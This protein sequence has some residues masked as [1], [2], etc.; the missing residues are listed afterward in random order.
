HLTRADAVKVLDRLA[1]AGKAAT[2]GRTLAYARAAYRWAEKRAM[3]PADPFQRLPFP[4]AAKSRDRLLT[5]IELAEAWGASGKLGCPWGPFYRLALLTL[6]RRDE[7]AGMRWTEISPDYRLWSI[8]GERMKNG[9][10]HEVYLSEPVREV[11]RTIPRIYGRDYVFS[12]TGKT[13]VS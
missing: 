5:D 6:Q 2:V 13:P 7:V 8:A 3:V 9:R 4:A 11:L 10:P 12:T 1:K